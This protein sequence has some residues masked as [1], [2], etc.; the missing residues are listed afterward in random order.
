M[1]S[2]RQALERTRGPKAGN[3]KQGA[4]RARDHSKG[5]PG[6]DFA[7][8]L[9][10]G[11]R[12]CVLDRSHL[13][14]NRVIAHDETDPRAKSFDMLRTQVLQTMDQRN[15][16]VLGITSPTP[17]CG[18]TVTA[19]NLAFS[20]A[21][22][23]DRS[24]VLIDLDLQKP[25][26]ANTL[27]FNVESG[28]LAVLQ[29]RTD[30]PNAIVAARAGNYHAM[31]LPAEGRIP[32]SSAWIA[33]RAMSVMLQDIKGDYQASTLIV[34]LPPMLVSDDV[35]A[36]LPQ[37]DCVLLVAAAGKT[38]R[39]EIEECNKH[40]QSTEVVRLVLNKAQERTRSYYY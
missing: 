15:W 25:Q 14:S 9:G 12:E 30:L 39:A 29:D 40:L 34:D 21:R 13:D 36:L 37:L 4:D 31:V 5:L 10:R 18:K 23:P 19:V 3:A 33:S 16:R 8:P 11:I 35:I 27:G 2:I 7:D 20:I 1:E 24:V 6:S 28:L 26:V 38:T 32:D 22:Q 17:D